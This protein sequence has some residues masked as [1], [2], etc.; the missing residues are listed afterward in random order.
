MDI[1][2]LKL[3]EDIYSYRVEVLK[4]IKEFNEL[5]LQISVFTKPIVNNK[6]REFLEQF[7]SYFK[8]H[9]FTIESPQARVRIA[10]NDLHTINLTLTNSDDSGA[11]FRFD[12]PTKSKYQTVEIRLSKESAPLLVWKNNLNDFDV[13]RIL[14]SGYTHYV[15]SLFSVEEL[16]KLIKG[17][18]ENIEW[19][20][21]TVID[22]YKLEYTY[23]IY[24]SDE[25]FKDFREFFEDYV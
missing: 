15:N 23:G 5:L 6:I 22:L 3:D 8:T 14:N 1:N 9:N 24:D 4:K 21:S 12:I 17:L 2:E 7:S 16:E 10:E 13:Q 20:K 18:D 11:S 19:Y 25:E